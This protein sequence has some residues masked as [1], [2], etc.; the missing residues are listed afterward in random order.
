VAA[1]ISALLGAQW[2]L[3][4]ILYGLLQGVAG[5]APYAATGYRINKLPVALISGLL[6]GA[7]AGYLDLVLYY[8]T[9]K[10]SWKLGQ[11]GVAAASGLVVAGLG[12]WLLTRALARTG[13]LDRFPSGRERALV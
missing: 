12:G 2:G 4:T 6:A 10:T 1:A 7:A 11:V 3:T 5:E 13:V 8:P 9:W